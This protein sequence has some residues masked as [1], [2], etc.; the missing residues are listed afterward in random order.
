MSFLLDANILCRLA[1]PDDPQ[2][3]E[4]RT[5]T[6]AI[7]IANEQTIT[8][9]QVVREFWVVA[10]RPRD[11]KGLGMTPVEAAKHLQVFNEFCSFRADNPI[12]HENWKVLVYT[13]NVSGKEAHDAN[14]VAAMQAHNIPSI[15]TFDA[16]D[17][18][19]YEKLVTV[20]T[21]EQVVREYALAQ[22]KLAKPNGPG[23]TGQ[24]TS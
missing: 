4:A 24:Q 13:H 7:V 19:R 14:H 18:R 11:Q 6:R 2:H 15:L 10:T 17:F 9:P 12:V 21:P 22:E 1:R 16:G 20:W 3:Q 5:A 8:T 23:N